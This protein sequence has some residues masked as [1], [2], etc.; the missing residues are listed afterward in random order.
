MSGSEDQADDRPN[1]EDTVSALG[2]SLTPGSQIGSF[3]IEGELGRGG[4][5]VVYLAYDTQ[6]KRPVA[7]KSLAPEITADA[8]LRSRQDREA[9]VLARLNHPNIAAIY[10]RLEDA[11]GATYLVLEYVPGQTLAERIRL[12]PLGLSEAISIASQV[13]AAIAAAHEQGVVHRDLKPGNI[14]ITPKG[15]AKVLDFGLAKAADAGAQN[16]PNTTTQLRVVIGTPAYM[17][18]EQAAGDPVDYRS[19][20]WS[21]GLVVY[22]MLAGAFPFRGDTRR[23]V[24]HSILHEEPPRLRRIRRDVPRWLERMVLQMMEKDPAR[25][26]TNVRELL[27]ELDRLGRAVQPGDRPTAWRRTRRQVVALLTAATLCVGAMAWAYLRPPAVSPPPSIVVLPFEDMSPQK[28][29]EYFCDGIVEELINALTHIKDLRVIARTSAFAFKGKNTDVRDIGRQLQVATVLEGSVRKAGGKLRI[30]AQLVNAADRRHLWSNQY[31]RDVDDVLAIQGQITQ[32]IVGEL[33]L[34][35]LNDEKARI[36]RRQPMD[37]AARDA[38]WSGLSFWNRRSEEDLHKAIEYFEKAI[39]KEPNYALAHALLGSCYSLLPLYST[40][41]PPDAVQKGKAAALRALQIEE[42]LPEAHAALGQILVRYEWDWV[43]AENHFRRAIE[44]NP[45]YASA[46]HWYSDLH[47]YR[48]RYAQAVQE[49]EQAR[50]LDPM[51]VTV[52]RN[53]GIVLCYSGRVDRGLEVLGD[54]LEM[55]PSQVYT[56]LFLGRVYLDKARYEDA[57]KEFALEETI[58]KGSHLWARAY[59][60]WTYAKMGESQEAQKRLAE[61]VELSRRQYVSP[62]ILGLTYFVV[63]RSDAG[64]ELLDKAW[65]QR[66]PWLCWI[67]LPGMADGVRQNPKYGVLLKKMNL[68]E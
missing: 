33:K 20:I 53:L 52:C 54:A 10:E 14:K 7:I 16:P 56:H 48:A 31:D 9:K 34:R 37:P 60:I 64:F 43:G 66:D 45:G 17:S 47:L 28:D 13:A 30:T 15:T 18:P 39:Q 11:Q 19:D 65:T 51:S 36:S 38:Y 67:K 32:A 44:L 27:A 58:A 61:M 2:G 23:D 40:S 24:L 49:L 21:L 41:A 42:T 8:G 55:D 3:R 63:G 4:M 5:G 6:L 59:T 46:H 57:L 68:E 62:A 50:A 29:Q 22:E 26:P 1:S 12:G 35:L 25:R